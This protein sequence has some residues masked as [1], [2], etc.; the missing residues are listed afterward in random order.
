MLLTLFFL[1]FI[2]RFLFLL[3]LGNAGILVL[4]LHDAG[5]YNVL[6]CTPCNFQSNTLGNNPLIASGRILAYF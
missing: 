5:Y 2:P 1:F 4:Y 6:T 3:F